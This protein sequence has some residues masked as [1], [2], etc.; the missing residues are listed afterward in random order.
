MKNLY[1]PVPPQNVEMVWSKKLWSRTVFLTRLTMLRN[2][3]IASLID[4]YT[5]SLSFV[6]EA[7]N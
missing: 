6:T 5:G 2:T 3:V 7:M 1:V 4:L